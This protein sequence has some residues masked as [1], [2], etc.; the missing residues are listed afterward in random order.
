LQE[1][2]AVVVALAFKEDSLA[3]RDR[4]GDRAAVAADRM[5]RTLRAPREVAA[6]A[7][8]CVWAT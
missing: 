1:A 6:V 4:W 2:A 7:V 3:S 5:D 8:A